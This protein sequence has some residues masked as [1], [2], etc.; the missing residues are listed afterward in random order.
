MFPLIL[1]HEQAFYIKFII[2]SVVTRGSSPTIRVCSCWLTMP[3]SLSGGYSYK[4]PFSFSSRSES[5]D[6]NTESKGSHR[7]ANGRPLKASANSMLLRESV[8]RIG[9]LPLSIYISTGDD[10]LTRSE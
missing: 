3:L 5:L 6:L 7:S 9:F 4:I 1:F 8:L 10:S 2:H